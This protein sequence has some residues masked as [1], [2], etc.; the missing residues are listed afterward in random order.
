M[1]KTEVVEILSKK[2]KL[3]K[4]KCD[5]L[6]NEFKSLILDVCSKGDEV[7]IRNFGKFCMQEKKERKFLNPQTKRFYVCK[8]KKLI[9]FKGYKNFKYALN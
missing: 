7:N 8:A 6:L 9:N 3:P 5:L 2:T 4:N 1:N